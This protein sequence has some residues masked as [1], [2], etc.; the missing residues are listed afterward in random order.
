MQM[1]FNILKH[2]QFFLR[3]VA[4]VLFCISASPVFSRE[5]LRSIGG[6]VAKVSDG[7]TIQVEDSLGTKLK[8]RLYGIDAPETEKGNKPGQ[9]HGDESYRALQSKVLGQKVRLDV[10]DIDK[11]RRLV[12]L[13]WMSDRN[14][15]H[16]MITEGHAWAYRKYLDQTRRAEFIS[17]EEQARKNRLGLWQQDYP[18]P[19]WEFRK[20][21][22]K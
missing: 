16:E 22:S 3:T 7:D 6:I 8:V 5:P 15:N 11:Y 2:K 9:P 17:S 19:P 20:A 4:L 10:L 21:L 12:A 18:Q 1:K 13:V 14:I